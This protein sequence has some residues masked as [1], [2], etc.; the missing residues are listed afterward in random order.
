MGCGLC[1]CSW[2]WNIMGGWWGD[3]PV[4][5]GPPVAAVAPAGN[6]A[7]VAVVRPEPR[8]V[9]VDTPLYL[10]PVY[11]DYDSYLLRQD[12]QDALQ[13]I[14]GALT[15]RPQLR[16]TLEGFCDERG[17]GDYNVALG[18]RRAAGALQYLIDLGISRS[19]LQTISYGEERQICN[20]H[21][22]TCWWKNRRVEFRQE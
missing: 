5:P 17:S 14:A 10:P 18:E 7:N 20:E 1:G 12:T 2:C 15:T 9:G 6:N 13:A 11:F 21:S 22:E 16:L 19:R 4:E 8:T 3:D